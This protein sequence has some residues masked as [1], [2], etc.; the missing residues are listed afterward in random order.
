[1]IIPT[2]TS[3]P[4]GPV[5]YYN[6]CTTG[7][8]CIGA[9]HGGSI[10]AVFI[11]FWIIVALFQ[12]YITPTCTEWSSSFC[13]RHPC[14]ASCY[15]TGFSSVVIYFL[16]Q[17]Y[18]LYTMN[19]ICM[20]VFLRFIIIG[21]ALTYYYMFLRVGQHY[22]ISFFLSSCLREVVGLRSLRTFRLGIIF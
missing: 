19:S 12:R 22:S 3:T 6:Q 4:S 10:P 13:A 1:M 8:S 9:H 5:D 15:A 11:L 7:W 18:I 20:F 2:L 17:I 21:Y 16:K 14:C